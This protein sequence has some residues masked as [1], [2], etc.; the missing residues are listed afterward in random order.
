MAFRRPW[1]AFPSL[2]RAM[3][4]RS[5]RNPLSMSM[6]EIIGASLSWSVSSIRRIWRRR[7]VVGSLTVLQKMSVS[8]MEFWEEWESPRRSLL[9]AKKKQFVEHHQPLSAVH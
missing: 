7:R 5:S 6:V 1:E 2:L 9:A 8:L 4:I 3:G